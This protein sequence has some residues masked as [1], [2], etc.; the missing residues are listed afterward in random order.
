LFAPTRL[1]EDMSCVALCLAIVR[2]DRAAK[3]WAYGTWTLSRSVQTLGRTG[4]GCAGSIGT[5][6]YRYR[7]SVGGDGSGEGQWLARM[8]QRCLSQCTGRPFVLLAWAGGDRR[9]HLKPTRVRL[10]S[11]SAGPHSFAPAIDRHVCQMK[12]LSAATVRRRAHT[13]E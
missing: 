9:L 10:A 2:V 5:G 6:G 8:R 1:A 7:S 4:T 11:V 12:Q 3:G 13:T